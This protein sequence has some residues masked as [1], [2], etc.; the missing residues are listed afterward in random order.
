VTTKKKKKKKSIAKKVLD[1]LGLK[2]PT[3]YERKPKPKPYP[4]PVYRAA[5]FTDVYVALKKMLKKYE[6]R[7]IVRETEKEYF[8]R[9]PGR[10]EDEKPFDLIG[11]FFGAGWVSFHNN[12]LLNESYV[13]TFPKELLPRRHGQTVLNFSEIDRPLFKILEREVKAVIALVEKHGYLSSDRS[14]ASR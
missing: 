11:I 1:D 12:A 3:R 13:K 2:P 8:L 14:A 6:K 9:V 10:H 7:F 5:D 4:P